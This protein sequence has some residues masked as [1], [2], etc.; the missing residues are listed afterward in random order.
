MLKIVL[1]SWNNWETFPK[2]S[3]KR[4]QGSSKVTDVHSA[5]ICAILQQADPYYDRLKTYN[6]HTVLKH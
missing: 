3:K 2:I 6:P 4:D 1:Y 5:T